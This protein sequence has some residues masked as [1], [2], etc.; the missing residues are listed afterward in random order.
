MKYV[1]REKEYTRAIEAEGY[2][3]LTDAPTE[4]AAE[5]VKAA[6]HSSLATP[7]SYAQYNGNLAEIAVEVEEESGE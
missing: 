6:V 7:Y 2:I 5:E 4:V 3:I 1:Y